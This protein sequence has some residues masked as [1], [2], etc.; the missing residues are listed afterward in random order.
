M[1][2]KYAVTHYVIFS[3]VCHFPF[4]GSST[5]FSN[6][7]FSFLKVTE[8]H[9]ATKNTFGSCHF[10]LDYTFPLLLQ[11]RGDMSNVVT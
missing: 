3:I 4:Y 11:Y 5:L 2:E 10:K 9:E 7:L 8:V 1:D 6:Y